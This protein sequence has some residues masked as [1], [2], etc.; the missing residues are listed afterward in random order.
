MKARNEAR[1]IERAMARLVADVESIVESDARLDDI[2]DILGDS[3]WADL[4]P[5][6][7]TFMRGVLAGLITARN[8]VRNEF[9]RGPRRP[10]GGSA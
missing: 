6:H 5:A 2:K 4:A 1:E 3:P 10:V 8:E 9:L 7:E